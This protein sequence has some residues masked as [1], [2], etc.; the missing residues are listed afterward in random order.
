MNRKKGRN[1]GFCG[2]IVELV[3]KFDSPTCTVQLVHNTW[4]CG[5]LE[6]C[7]RVRPEPDDETGT[8]LSR[9]DI[10]CESKVVIESHDTFG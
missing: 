6:V 1:T 3:G 4:R 8:S 2:V 9:N 5:H 7:N 10:R